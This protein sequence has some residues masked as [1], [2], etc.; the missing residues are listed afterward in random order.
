MLSV[1]E[2]QWTRQAP[3]DRS[4]FKR[5]CVTL[6]SSQTSNFAHLCSQRGGID[7]CLHLHMIP[8]VFYWKGKF[9]YELELLASLL[10]T[11][12]TKIAL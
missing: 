2:V 12:F 11:V 3:L 8:P 7:H 1:G 9:F 5:N 4:A 6:L 10:S